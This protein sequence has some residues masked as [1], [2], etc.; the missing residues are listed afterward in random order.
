MSYVDKFPSFDGT[1]DWF[2][3]KTMDGFDVKQ[4]AEILHMRFHKINDG[5]VDLSF[6]SEAERCFRNVINAALERAAKV[7]EEWATTINKTTWNTSDIAIC[8][9]TC[10]RVAFEIRALKDQ[11]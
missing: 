8:N 9:N 3:D 6:E 2:R 5:T 4:M 10:D 7:A 1:N 11:T